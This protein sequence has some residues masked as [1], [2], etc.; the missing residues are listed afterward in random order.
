MTLICASILLTACD[1]N[2]ASSDVETY[3]R[4][5]GE[6]PKCYRGALGNY[7]S[8]FPVTEIADVNSASRDYNYPNPAASNFPVGLNPDNYQ[9]P[10]RLADTKGAPNFKLVEYFT[11]NELMPYKKGRWGVISAVA[12][13]IFNR[14]RIAA[15]A[16]IIVNS[17]YRSPARNAATDDSSFW[18][19][20]MYGDAFDF[21]SPNKSLKQLRTLCQNHGASFVQ[22]YSTHV[23]CDWRNAAKDPDFYA[24]EDVI[25]PTITVERAM[26]DLAKFNWWVEDN[27]LIAEVTNVL[28]EDDAELLYQWEVTL[29]DGRIYTIDTP[30]LNF[31]LVMP[32]VYHLRAEVGG[33]IEFSKSFEWAPHSH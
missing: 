15:N 23:H 21:Y 25:P 12:L 20:H 14:L 27:Q 1:P 8:C 30:T 9:P 10:L 4:V 24:V 2:A 6:N 19:R 29:P 18:S 3:Q 13:D 11:L 17:A 22:I 5:L 28:K 32:G 26:Q 7:D 33:H 31:D 16:T